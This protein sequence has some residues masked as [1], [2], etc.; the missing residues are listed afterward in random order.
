[1]IKQLCS[2]LVLT[3]QAKSGAPGHGA[4]ALRCVLKRPRCGVLALKTE[5]LELGSWHDARPR[6]GVLSLVPGTA[7]GRASAF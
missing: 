2:I 7:Q 6:P 3:Y 4:R 5:R 1:M